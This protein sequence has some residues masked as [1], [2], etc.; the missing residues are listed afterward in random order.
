M[1]VQER[2]AEP[3]GSLQPRAP[4]PAS[5]PEYSTVGMKLDG[6][7][8]WDEKAWR[9]N[10][11]HCNRVSADTFSPVADT[12]ARHAARVMILGLLPAPAGTEAA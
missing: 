7:R 4:R 10:I 8:P 5:K 12:P 1:L 9:T 6:A 11:P 2:V 3:S